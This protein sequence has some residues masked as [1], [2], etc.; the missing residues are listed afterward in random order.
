MEHKSFSEICA[1]DENAAAIASAAASELKLHNRRER[2]EMRGRS[3][4]ISKGELATKVQVPLKLLE[5]GRQSHAI[6]HSP[7]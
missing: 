2:T 4:G 7:D 6:P 5:F 3:S 1:A